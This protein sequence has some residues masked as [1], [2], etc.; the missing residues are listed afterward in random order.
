MANERVLSFL[1]E[2]KKEA[3]CY[4]LITLFMSDSLEKMN[5]TILKAWFQSFK[6]RDGVQIDFGKRECS[7]G[8]ADERLKSKNVL[9]PCS[10]M[11]R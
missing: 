6:T 9:A 4:I 7:F 8:R 3:S 1:V 2:L 11:D 10:Q 5:I